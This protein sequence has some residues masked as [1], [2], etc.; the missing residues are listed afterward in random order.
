MRTI[1]LLLL[2][3][4]ECFG[5]DL[6]LHNAHIIDPATQKISRGALLIRNGK[7]EQ[8]LDA[9]PKD[10]AGEKI[11]LAGKFVVPGFN[12]MHTHSFGNV[13]PGN[14]VQLLMT[15]GTAKLMLYSGVTGFLDLFSMESQ[16]FSDREQQR[17][18]AMAG[19]D[20]YCA[21]PILTCT[22]GHG[23]EYG[24]PTRVINSPA[25]AE[26]EIGEL[27]LKRPDVIKIVYDHAAAQY[28]PT[29]DHA[30]MEAAIKA[31]S[32]HGIKT[33]IHIGTWQDAKEAVLAG[34]TAITHLYREE[35]PDELVA[36]MK[37]KNVYAIPTLCV[38]S[39]LSNFTQTP[40][41]LESPLLE[42]VTT[43]ALVQAFRDTASF[44]PRTKAWLARQKDRRAIFYLSV[45]KL[46]DAGV[47]IMTGTD[48]GNLGTFQG[49]SLHREVQLLNDAGLSAWQALAAATTTPGEFFGQPFGVRPGSIA[50]L[51]VLNASPIENLANT[52]N[53]AM[54]IH[55]GKVVAREHL[56]Q[57]D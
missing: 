55:R 6:L 3:A 36:V 17:K 27:A 43:P 48:G 46:A 54:V 31:A 35:I 21:G 23:T 33:V 41:L 52:Q 14:N 8:A 37:E 30:T 2:L 16:I 18:G 49:Y 10:F 15:P 39:E 57:L 51:V 13:A 5:Q 9:V 56:L 24:V 32:K 26:K 53:I 44:D 19:A 25:E 42:S 12:D 45:K 38:T 50:N 40:T 34:A 47:K 7:I 28:F 29:I 11:D 20:I 1:L 22:K 4:L